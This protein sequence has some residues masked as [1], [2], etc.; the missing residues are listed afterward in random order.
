MSQPLLLSRVIEHAAEQFGNVEIVS[1][2]GSD[3]RF[4]YTYRDCAKRSRQLANGLKS[5]GLI[6]GDYVA[7]IAWNSHRHLESYFAV[8]GAGMVMHT[9]NPRLPTSQLAY[10]LNHAG[11]RVVLFDADFVDLVET[12]APLCPNVIAWVCLCTPLELPASGGLCSYTSYEALLAEQE[13]VF[14]WPDL[15]EEQAAALCYT[16]GTTGNPKGVLYS[17]RAITLVALSAC[18]PD[19][20]SLSCDD[21]LL[22][23]VPMFH[24]NAWCLPYSAMMV[25]ARLVLPGA[26]LDGQSL[27]ELIARESVTVSV[28]VPTVWSNL[29]QYADVHATSLSPLKRIVVGGAAMP[30]SLISK[31]LAQHK[32]DVRHG[33]GMT[34]TT[35][36]AT[37]NVLNSAQRQLPVPEQAQLLSRQGRSLFGIDLKVIDESGTSVP[38]DGRSQG[39]LM[40][41]GHWIMEKYHKVDEPAHKDGWLPTGDIATLDADGF[42]QIRDR[43]K[44]LVK[45]GGEWISSQSLEEAAMDHPSVALAAV[46]GVP[47][48]KWDERPLMFVKCKPGHALDKSD[49]LLALSKVL[50]RWWLPDEIRFV[51][52]LP[53]GGTGKVLKGRLRE[54]YAEDASEVARAR[55]RSL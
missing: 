51:T 26:R 13:Q 4:S 15:D 22:P 42:M 9:C 45:S 40:V 8:S 36:A 20:V 28:G 12:L 55:E 2:S 23:V 6:A 43:A 5:L 10:I 16:S 54:L 39:E 50:P 7:S 19:V 35:G 27:C 49:L 37:I 29:L 25:G 44:D 11:D 53:I 30:R 1:I 38:R 17:H 52:E 14:A 3:G 24:I 31:L 48:P 34:E 46:I 33:W 32:I 18:L 21:S 41:R 47:H